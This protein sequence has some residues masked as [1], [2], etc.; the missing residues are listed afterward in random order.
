MAFFNRDRPQCSSIDDY[1]RHTLFAKRFTSID[2]FQSALQSSAFVA[3]DTE[4]SIRTIF[5]QQN[6]ISSTTI[7]V[8]PSTQKTQI[9]KRMQPRFGNECD[10]NLDCLDELINKLLLEYEARRTADNK[11]RLTLISRFRAFSREV[12]PRGN[13]PSLKRTLNPLG[14]SR[15]DVTPDR[16][17]EG[18]A[19]NAGNDAVITLAVLEGLQWSANQARLRSFQAYW[20]IIS[21]HRGPPNL[22]RMP[23]TAKVQTVD[24][25][26]LPKSLDSAL[27]LSRAF[28]DEYHPQNISVSVYG[29]QLMVTSL[30]DAALALAEMES[31]KNQAIKQQREALRSMVIAIEEPNL[32]TLFS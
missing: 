3:L 4:S 24:Q 5:A 11:D 12:V 17:S 25:T 22:L 20:R 23:F 18:A 6:N 29:K 30:H 14:Y 21:S 31:V 7:N 8:A 28:F 10:A 2:N 1:K 32:E 13:V 9:L 16:K 26:L 15:R 27:C 19:H